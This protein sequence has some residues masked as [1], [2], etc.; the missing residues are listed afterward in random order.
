MDCFEEAQRI[1]KAISSS[2]NSINLVFAKQISDDFFH[3]LASTVTLSD[4]CKSLQL[5]KTSL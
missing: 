4:L 5:L 1:T 2:R 3:I